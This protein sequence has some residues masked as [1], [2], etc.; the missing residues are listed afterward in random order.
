MARP[1]PARQVWI[2]LAADGFL[3]PCLAALS[4]MLRL[5]DHVAGLTLLALGNGAP[6]IFSQAR[7][8]GAGGGGRGRERE[9]QEREMK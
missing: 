6:D 1:G 4:R 9:R 8:R 5:S 2:G 7:E 3:C